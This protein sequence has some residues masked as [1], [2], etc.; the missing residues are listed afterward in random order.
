MLLV[1]QC[2]IENFSI[3]ATV[4]RGL[5]SKLRCNRKAGTH[6]ATERVEDNIVITLGGVLVLYARQS[7]AERTLGLLIS[8]ITHFQGQK[9][10]QCDVSVRPTLTLGD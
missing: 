8:K 1:K 10:Y 9:W 3:D 5:E 2:N 4:V 6:A 7:A